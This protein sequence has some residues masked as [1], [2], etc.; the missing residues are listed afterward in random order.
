MIFNNKFF[1]F[2]NQNRNIII[3]VI[4]ICAFIVLLI[5]TLNGFFS[6]PQVKNEDNQNNISNDVQ[7]TKNSVISD[8]TLDNKT[9][10]DNYDVLKK[11]VQLCNENNIEEAYSLLSDECKQNVY[12]NLEG[13]TQNYVNIVFKNKK[14]LETKNWIEYEDYVTY[15][16]TYTGDIIS[17][18]DVNSEKFQDYITIDCESNKLNINKYIRRKQIN[19]TTEKN[20]IKFTINYVDIYKDY[21]IYNVDVENKNNKEIVLDNLT[22]VSGT[23]IETSEDTKINCS[24]YEAGRNNFTYGPGISKN[25]KLK[26]IKQY[27]TD[28]EDKKIIFS[29]AILNE[30]NVEEID[31]EL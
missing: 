12:P 30:D 13:F 3:L 15:L 10:Q 17:T 26:F 20:N 5:K 29:T 6:N 14:N 24:N 31:L 7:K 11:F 9:A 1:R 4:V 27:N 8:S 22:S 19:K 16:V 21:E 18:G 25:M 2:V 28:I 23:Y